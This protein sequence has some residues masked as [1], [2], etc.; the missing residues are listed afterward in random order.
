MAYETEYR[1]RRSRGRGRKPG[2]VDY[3]YG[4]PIRGMY[5]YSLDYG[6]MGGPETDSESIPGYDT[7]RDDWNGPRPEYEQRHWAAAEPAGQRRVQRGPDP[8]LRGRIGSGREQGG[9]WDP[10]RSQGYGPGFRGYYSGDEAARARSR[11]WNP[12]GYG[13]DFRPVPFRGF[14][15]WGVGGSTR[16]EYDREAESVR[17]RRQEWERRWDEMLSRASERGRGGRGSRPDRGPAGYG[18]DF[19][20]RIERY[21]REQA[22]HFRDRG[23]RGGRR[24]R[25]GGRVAPGGD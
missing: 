19:F 3:G 2:N 24:G 21:E 6:A 12:A 15:G 20:G 10:Y 7:G 25:F 8:R 18:R 13:G 4:V 23:P 5:D 1:S 11:G 16:N 17:R 22:E 14:R 9:G